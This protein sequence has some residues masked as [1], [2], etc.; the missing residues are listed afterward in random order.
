[1]ERPDEHETHGRPSVTLRYRLCDQ[2]D[3]LEREV[4]LEAFFG[5]GTD[6]PEDLFHDV[7][8]VPQHAAVSLLDDIEAADVAVTELTFAGSEGEKLTVKET[9]W[10]HGYSRV[11]EIMQQ[12]GE[13]SEP[14]WEVIVD[15]RREAGETYEL[16]RLGRERGAVVP[17]HHAVS[18][19]RPDGSKQDVTLFPSR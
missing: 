2:E 10:N 4:E 15:L 9:F 3:W 14:Y 1:M 11:I 6:H 12:L 8:W 16:I 13:H 7:D 17:I 5:G 18:H 19:A